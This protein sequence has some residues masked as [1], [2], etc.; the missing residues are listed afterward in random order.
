LI[1]GNEHQSTDGALAAKHVKPGEEILDPCLMDIP[2]PGCHSG[3][4]KSSSSD[5]VYHVAYVATA[6]KGTFLCHMF[7]TSYIIQASPP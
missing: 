2:N 4:N 1:E 5:V 6:T 7:D 3:T